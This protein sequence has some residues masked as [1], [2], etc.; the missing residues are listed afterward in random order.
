MTIK[1]DDELKKAIDKAGELLANG[2]SWEDAV[3]LANS[4][5]GNVAGKLGTSAIECEESMKA[6]DKYQDD[7]LD[8]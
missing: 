3:E 5:A 1:N 8:K 7:F 4:A 2:Y 6:I